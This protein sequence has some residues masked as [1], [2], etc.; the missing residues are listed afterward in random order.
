[1]GRFE[2]PPYDS[3]SLRSVYYVRELET[4]K[5]AQV[6]LFSFFFFR[7]FCVCCGPNFFHPSVL[8]FP[9]FSFS[10][11]GARVLDYA[12]AHRLGFRAFIICLR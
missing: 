9:C 3:E 10:G 1:M 11:G 4:F 5:L 12:T 2:R 7:F 8:F 6:T